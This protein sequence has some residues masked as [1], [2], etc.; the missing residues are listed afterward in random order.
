M[1]C[2]LAGA[3]SVSWCLQSRYT[4][5]TI[6]SAC[7]AYQ[8]QHWAERGADMS[9]G[10]M[11]SLGLSV[12]GV[13]KVGMGT[14]NVHGLFDHLKARNWMTTS[15]AVRGSRASITRSAGVADGPRGGPRRRSSACTQKDQQ[16]E[17]MWQLMGP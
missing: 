3:L 14:F 16:R 10:C 17:C 7:H 6:V 2:R 9:I 5:T 8:I 13:R 15:D 1:D 4:Y 12:Y 11:G